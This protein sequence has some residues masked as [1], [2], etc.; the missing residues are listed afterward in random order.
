MVAG[1][2]PARAPGSAVATSGSGGRTVLELARGLDNAGG[3]E[4]ISLAR[5]PFAVRR[6]LMFW[7]ALLLDRTAGGDPLR[8]RRLVA[9][10]L[11]HLPGRPDLQL[12][13][14]IALGT[15]CGARAVSLSEHLR[16]LH[17]ALDLLARLPEA[18]LKAQML[19]QVAAILVT[20]GDP[21]WRRLADR[22]L[23][24]T[25][26]APSGMAEVAAYQAVGSGA[27][28]AGHNDL[29]RR[30]LAAA[31][32]RA[33]TTRDRR[34]ERRTV[35]RL[36]LLDYCHGRWQGL[37]DRAER[38]ATDLS[39]NSTARLEADNV[40]A[41]VEMEAVAGCLALAEGDLDQA[42]VR[43]AGT[44]ESATR[45]GLGDLLPIPGNAL[46][47][48]AIALAD[49]ERALE[50]GQ[51]LAAAVERRGA[52][53]PY[54]R[55]LPAL[56]QAMV[57]AGRGSEVL[58]LLNQVRDRIRG[59]DVP[60]GPAATDRVQGLVTEQARQWLPAAAHFCAAA[61]RYEPLGCRYEAAQSREH[62]A[63][64]LFEAGDP[65]AGRTL[66]A[67][68]ATYQHLGASWDL[69]RAYRTAAR[70]GLPLLA[71][72]RQGRRCQGDQLSPRQ[73]QVAQ[74]AAAG[75]TNDEIA[76]RLSLSAR[77][78]DKHIGAALRRLGLHSRRS[79]AHYL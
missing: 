7:L 20:V 32:Q 3:A 45:A 37:R 53:A 57:T 58:G 59:L 70:F 61:D 69:A 9:E 28:Y 10:S 41:R 44:V 13:A 18:A 39:E 15:P 51:R 16:W 42:R 62:A 1:E 8:Q 33:V 74:L 22:M 77:T 46:V 6:E 14:M 73:Q 26:Q 31:H 72:H 4:S 27:C 67:A 40:D 12:W 25:G 21:A 64:C 24:Q 49:G 36:A 55:L 78:V 30:L 5:L 68:A 65:R 29:A 52:W 54:A 76:R 19:G 66:R 23:A 50:T 56:A 35:A 75:L 38:L 71:A 60:L 79:L 43:L 47:R 63:E 11:D 48:L 17:R 2:A 34:T